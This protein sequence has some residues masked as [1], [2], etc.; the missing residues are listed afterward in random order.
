MKKDIT[1]FTE[2]EFIA[3]M[4]KILA[5]NVA[6]TDD[7]LDVLLEEFCEITGHPDGTD[8]IYYPEADSSGSAEDVTR[9][10]KEWRA[11]Q[12]LPGFKE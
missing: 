5:E 12:G 6:P 1:D 8:L 3:F 4:H 11:A 7:V 2:D 10:V 9:V